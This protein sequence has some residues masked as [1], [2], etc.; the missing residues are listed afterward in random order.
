M[1]ILFSYRKIKFFSY[2]HYLESTIHAT[3]RFEEQGNQQ[4][5]MKEVI[6]GSLASEKVERFVYYCLKIFT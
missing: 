4:K 5:I 1:Y 6:I 3:P 2:C